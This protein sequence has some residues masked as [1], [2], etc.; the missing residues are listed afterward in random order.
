MIIKG[1]ISIEGID[2]SGKTYLMNRL[3]D[4]F[5]KAGHIKAKRIAFGRNP[6]DS[7]FGQKIRDILS[8]VYHPKSERIIELLFVAD[9]DEF[10]EN[11]K[12]L[13]DSNLGSMFITDRF[14]HSQIAYCKPNLDYMVRML[15]SDIPRPEYVIQII[16]P[17]EVA[18]DRINESRG[19]IE[20]YENSDFLET[21]AG[22]YDRIL[23]EE[24]VFTGLK[25]IKI[26][27]T[28]PIEE[29]IEYLFLQIPELNK[30]YETV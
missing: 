28:K 7:F 2:G 5:E 29:N 23:C 8:N 21:V 20:I 30:I 1:L 14:I 15:N 6:T 9:R 27:G 18:M 11:V 24:E 22:K 25:L 26:D 16:V 12:E 17:V 4:M 19:N 3:I 10:V 13:L